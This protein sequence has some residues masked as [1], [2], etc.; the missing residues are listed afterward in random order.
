MILCVSRTNL[1]CTGSIPV[2]KS[3]HLFYCNR[4]AC[5]VYNSF[6][7]GFANPVLDLTESGKEFT[8]VGG[9]GIWITSLSNCFAEYIYSPIWNPVV[10]SALQRRCTHTASCFTVILK[11]G[12]SVKTVNGFILTFSVTWMQLPSPSL[13]PIWAGFYQFCGRIL[14]LQEV[15]KSSCLSW[16]REVLRV[17]FSFFLCALLSIWDYTEGI[18]LIIKDPVF[19]PFLNFCSVLTQARIQL[20]SLSSA[21]AKNQIKDLASGLMS[22]SIS[23]HFNSSFYQVVKL[24]QRRKEL[25]FWSWILHISKHSFFFPTTQ[26]ICGGSRELWGDVGSVTGMQELS[27]ENGT[28]FSKCTEYK[29]LF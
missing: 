3:S 20:T 17:Q 14:I 26:S 19:K 22:Y 9:I 10:C 5:I 25:V 15:L 29:Q 21:S 8:E 4:I 7:E 2:G 1:L 24:H 13:V 11:R 6:N 18:D 23:F 27:G 12:E 28:S 16:Q